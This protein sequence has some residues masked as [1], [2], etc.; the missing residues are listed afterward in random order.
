MSGGGFQSDDADQKQG[1]EEQAKGRNR[2]FEQQDPYD[3]SSQCS[4]P[5]PDGI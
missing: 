1:Y 4:D 3:H 5:G 2:L